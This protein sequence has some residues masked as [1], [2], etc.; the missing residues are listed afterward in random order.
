MYAVIM[1][2][3]AHVDVHNENIWHAMMMHAH[4]QGQTH[5]CAWPLHNFKYFPLII[6]VFHFYLIKF[7]GSIYVSL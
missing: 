2:M 3:H 1:C 4:L 5:W 6:L 7:I